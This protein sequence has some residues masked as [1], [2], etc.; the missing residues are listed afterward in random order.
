MERITLTPEQLAA[1]AMERAV[2]QA[3]LLADIGAAATNLA[4]I[5]RL[6]LK[7]SNSTRLWAEFDLYKALREWDGDGYYDDTFADICEA[8]GV[9]EEGEE[10][11]SDPY[12]PDCYGDYLYEQRRDRLMMEEWDARHA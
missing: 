10:L 11:P 4:A 1:R 2:R 7:P 3:A 12:D 5:A 9:D 6:N 8:L